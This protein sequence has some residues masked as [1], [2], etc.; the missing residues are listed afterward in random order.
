MHNQD[1]MDQLQQLAD[2]A[3]ACARTSAVLRTWPPC[4]WP[5]RWSGP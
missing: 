3:A 1:L 2:A 4:R 5:R